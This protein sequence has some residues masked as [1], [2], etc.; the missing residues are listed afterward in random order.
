[1]YHK[2]N[3]AVLPRTIGGFIE[4]VMQHAVPAARIFADELTALNPPVNIRETDSRY[5]LHLVAA[6]LKKEDFKINL[7]RDILHVSFEQKEENNTQPQDGKWLRNEYRMKSFKRSF[8]LSEKVD[9]SKISATYN[10]GILVITLPKKEAAEP[11]VHE[12]S[13][14]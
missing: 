8:T 13:V 2:R 3:Y 10:D 7:D 4:D 1:M 14:N 9:V 6:G 12:I 5:E 11:S